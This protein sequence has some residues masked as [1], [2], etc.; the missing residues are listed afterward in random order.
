MDKNE[1]AILSDSTC[2]VPE[3]LIEQYNIQIVPQMIIWGDQQFRDRVDM[4]PH[5][6]YERL[7]SDRTRPTSS[8]PAISD[9]KEA[10]EQAAE[11]GAKEIMLTVTVQ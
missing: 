2:D 7:K 11:R 8:Q 3:N 9:F 6:F 1:I 4:Q 10:Y 5:E